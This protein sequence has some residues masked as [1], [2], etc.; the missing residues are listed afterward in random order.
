[1]FEKKA[2]DEDE[3]KMPVISRSL[4]EKAKSRKWSPDHMVQIN[5][6]SECFSNKSLINTES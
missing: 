2:G 1:M 5:R 4:I 3:Q 6:T